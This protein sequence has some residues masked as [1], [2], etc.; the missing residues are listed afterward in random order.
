MG[1]PRAVKMKDRAPAILSTEAQTNKRKVFTE[2]DEGNEGSAAQ[3]EEEVP[4][5]RVTR[6]STRARS[7]SQDSTS[8]DQSPAIASSKAKKATPQMTVKDEEEDEDAPEVISSSSKSAEMEQLQHLHEM[9]TAGKK[10]AS[11]KKRKLKQAN[12]EQAEDGDAELDVSV[13]EEVQQFEAAGGRQRALAPRQ[14]DMQDS[15]PAN[16]R[17]HFSSTSESGSTSTSKQIGHVTVHVLPDSDSA[18][19]RPNASAALSSFGQASKARDFLRHA[20]QGVLRTRFAQ[21]AGQKSRGPA[22]KFK[23]N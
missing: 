16:Q 9:V 13:F 14:E 18:E 17:V 22:K 23:L 11:K 5:A 12:R 15:E 4:E 21:F 2:D 3:D 8:Q 20:E 6:R 10:K 19:G 7:M 1:R